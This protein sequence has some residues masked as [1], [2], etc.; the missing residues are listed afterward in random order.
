ML[1]EAIGLF[2]FSVSDFQIEKDFKNFDVEKFR[3]GSRYY[4]VVTDGRSSRSTSRPSGLSVIESP[5]AAHD[6]YVDL[7]FSKIEFDLEKN[8]IVIFKSTLSGR[9]IYYCIDSKGDF[10][11]SSHISLLGEAGVKIEENTSVLPE[12]FVYCYISPPNTFYRG[13]HQLLAG[14]Q[15]SIEILS[16]RCNVKSIKN[17]EFHT[18]KVDRVNSVEKASIDVSDYLINT[19]R[20]IGA[21]QGENAFLLSGGLDSSIL[22]KIMQSQFPVDVT[23]STG[24]PF[25]EDA[26]N[27]EKKY[28]FTASK[29]FETDH[30][31]LEMTVE[32]YLRG[33]VEGISIAEEPIQYHAVLFH[34]LFKKG[35]PKERR[36]VICGQGADTLFGSDVNADLFRIQKNWKYKILKHEA[37][38]KPL[39]YLLSKTGFTRPKKSLKRYKMISETKKLP[40]GIEDNHIWNLDVLGDKEWACNYFKI[41]KRDLIRGRFN[42]IKPYL[43]KSIYDITTILIFYSHIQGIQSVISKLGEAQGRIILFPY[44]E[45]DLIRYVFQLPCE[46]KYRL[47]KN[48]LRNVARLHDIPEFIIDRPKSAIEIK[49]KD[50]AER[51]G[52]LEPVVPLASK[53]V[54]LKKIRETQSPDRN[55]AH[56]Y[57][58]ILSYSIWKRLFI[59]NEPINVILNELRENINK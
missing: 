32:D 9:P 39:E 41:N 1:C 13:I 14:C 37:F 59:N 7:M 33:L 20:K 56:I 24:Y 27:N 50:W 55:M 44:T 25:E 10:Y 8:E 16:D 38:W 53:I 57:W 5:L 42:L 34:L 23:Y 43:E 51:G 31:Y 40:D 28:A 29:I 58:N 4:M 2:L 48:I 54:N 52:P 6:N 12:F 35:I 36:I 17:F 21:F 18:R 3:A 49:R 46:I 30:R 26:E 45:D 47:K 11:C 22:L 19:F 15:L